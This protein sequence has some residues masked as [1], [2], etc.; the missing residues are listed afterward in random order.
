MSPRQSASFEDDKENVLVDS[1]AVS[2]LP[3][4]S[5][6]TAIVKRYGRFG[7]ILERIFASGVEARG[8]ERVPEDERSMKNMYNKCVLSAKPLGRVLMISHKAS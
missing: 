8:V 7:P 1:A 3:E 5:P 6:E 2:G 4:R